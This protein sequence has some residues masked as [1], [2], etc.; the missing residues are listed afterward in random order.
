MIDA[1]YLKEQV[2]DTVK[3]TL[4]PPRY[5]PRTL[6]PSVSPTAP[7]FTMLD[8]NLEPINNTM[9]VWLETARKRIGEIASLIDPL[10]RRYFR[11]A[12]LLHL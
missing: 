4:L 11:H 7:T 1:D 6:K 9:Y 5:P 8:E 12:H 3:E 2:F 10:A